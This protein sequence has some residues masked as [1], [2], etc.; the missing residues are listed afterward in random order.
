MT[1]LLSAHVDGREVLPEGW[2]VLGARAVNIGR[3]AG[4][5]GL[6]TLVARRAANVVAR[7][8]GRSARA[9]RRRLTNPRRRTEGDA[10]DTIVG[11]IHA[12]AS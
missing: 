8:L 12:V 6:T 11:A 5:A 1:F 2:D 10:A 7:R 9:T 3:I 4:G